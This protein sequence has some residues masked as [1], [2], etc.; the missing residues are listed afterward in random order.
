MHG[1]N[2]PS[3]GIVA[4]LKGLS[5]CGHNEAALQLALQDG[6]AKRKV[7]R[8]IAYRGDPYAPG[9]QPE[10]RRVILR[11]IANRESARR[12]RACRQDELDRLT[13]QVCADSAAV[14]CCAS[15]A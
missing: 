9:L 15:A 14:R 6:R 3:R 4:I 10:Q 2:T 8:P 5:T 11:R 1:P 13:Q 12:V 7:G